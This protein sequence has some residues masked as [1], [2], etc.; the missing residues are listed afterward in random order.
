MMKMLEKV[1]FLSNNEKKLKL[2]NNVN[3]EITLFCNNEKKLKQLSNSFFYALFLGNNE[4]K[5]K[6][7]SCL[8][9]NKK[10]M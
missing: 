10:K 2:S 4:K 1:K 6:L 3:L 7:I 8:N 9:S 5:L